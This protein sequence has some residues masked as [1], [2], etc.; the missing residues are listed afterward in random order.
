MLYFALITLLIAK[1]A[2]TSDHHNFNKRYR[3]LIM[4][5]MQYG[6]IL[7]ITTAVW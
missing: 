4:F 1:N 7:R 3:I 5:A 2:P 6:H